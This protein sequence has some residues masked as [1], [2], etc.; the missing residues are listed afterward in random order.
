M[1]EKLHYSG[2]PQPERKAFFPEI[3]LGN[4]SLQEEVL[5]RAGQE[6]LVYAIQYGSSVT[7]DASPTSLLDMIIVVENT[8]LFHQRNLNLDPHDYAQ[9][10]LVEWHHWLN[11]FGFNYYQTQIP[12]ENRLVKAKYAVISQ[13]NFIQGCHGTIDSFGFY[14]AGRMQKAAL[15]PLFKPEN[16]EKTAQIEQAINT[17]R[18]DG[19]WL[20]LG[21]LKKEFSF[22]ELLWTYVS[23]SYRADLRVEKPG[24]I[25][26]L[27]ERSQ[28]D[29]ERMLKPILVEFSHTNLIQPVEENRWRKIQ[30][31][32]RQEVDK[33]IRQIKI[34]TAKTNYIKNVLTVGLGKGV[35][36][37]LEKIRRSRDT[38]KI[39]A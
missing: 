3:S 5:K 31:P 6:N 7:N 9:P 24:K 17:A 2:L 15:R 25:Q 13:D 14:V 26:T 18:I 4:S 8:R 38:K 20:S 32:S 29:Y 36:Y 11:R 37:A 19:L 30:S 1:L 22:D 23:L 27:I 21:F 28:K 16:K 34:Q 33:R 35:K 12:L 10:H 39:L